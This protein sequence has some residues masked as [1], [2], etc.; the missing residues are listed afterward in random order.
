MR[1]RMLIES[2][3]STETG[4]LPTNSLDAETSKYFQKKTIRLSISLSLVRH[5]S[6]EQTLPGQDNQEAQLRTTNLKETC[7]A[8]HGNG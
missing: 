5:R 8:I 2:D 6:K 3:K 1:F 7:D 4:V